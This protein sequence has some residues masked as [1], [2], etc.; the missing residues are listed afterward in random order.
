[1]RRDFKIGW[2]RLSLEHAA[3]KIEGRAVAGAEEATQPVGAH[4][5]FVARF[6][7]IRWRATEVGTNTDHHQHFRLDRAGCVGCVRRLL[8]RHFGFRVSHLAIQ[9]G[10][11]IK[12]SLGPV[13]DPDRLA[14]PL[15]SHHL[16]AFQLADISLDWR[17]CSPRTLRWKQAGHERHQ[18]AHRAD[19]PDGCRR[20]DKPPP[21]A[22]HLP[23]IAHNADP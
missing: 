12:H 18:S 5:L 19:T 8:R 14:T 7:F 4:T 1:M 11:R 2:C 21:T 10:Q 15:H 13:D 3:G 6:E 22:V 17:P 16:T 23:L 20:V 9:L